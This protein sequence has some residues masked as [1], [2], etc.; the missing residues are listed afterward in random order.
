MNWPFITPAFC[1]GKCMLWDFGSTFDI[2]TVSFPLHRFGPIKFSGRI[3]EKVR[4]WLGIAIFVLTLPFLLDCGFPFTACVSSGPLMA[5]PGATSHIWWFMT[6]DLEVFW[7]MFQSGMISFDSIIQYI[8]TTTIQ[9]YSNLKFNNIG[10]G[11][12]NH[13]IS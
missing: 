13:I 2:F 5:W 11:S 9:W 6:H 4:S 8:H 12:M 3:T 10:S 1:N 7:K